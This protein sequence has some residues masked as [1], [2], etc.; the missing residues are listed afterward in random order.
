MKND[1]LELNKWKNMVSAIF[2]L[3][4]SKIIIKNFLHLIKH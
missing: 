4:V 3:L 1:N 2:S